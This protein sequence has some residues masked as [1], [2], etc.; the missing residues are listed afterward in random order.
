MRVTNDF[1]RLI[2]IDGEG[3]LNLLVGYAPSA[4]NGALSAQLTGHEICLEFQ[5]RQK[6]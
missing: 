4:P 5:K 2:S 6:P 1:D 3:I